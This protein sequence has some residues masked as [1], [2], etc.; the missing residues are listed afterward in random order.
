MISSFLG[1]QG[2]EMMNQSSLFPS[3]CNYH[4]IRL[5]QLGL[6]NTNSIPRRRPRCHVNH[7][8]IM[9][10]SVNNCCRHRP[11]N[12]HRST[13]AAKQLTAKLTRSRKEMAE[14]RKKY[15]TSQ[16]LQLPLCTILMMTH[17]GAAIMRSKVKQT[18]FVQS[19]V[20]PSL[21]MH[22]RDPL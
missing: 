8:T 19:S 22:L 16:T 21:C 14:K 20:L 18:N 4:P 2:R 5:I 3:Q 11:R 9:S 17:N 7:H 12:T 6:H 10:L 1:S 15:S 13:K